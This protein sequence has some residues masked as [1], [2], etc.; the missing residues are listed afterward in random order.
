MVVARHLFLTAAT[1]TM[2]FS[3]AENDALAMTSSYSG[4]GPKHTERFITSTPSEM[5]CSRVANTSS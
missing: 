3:M 1:T 4:V 5:A 2:P